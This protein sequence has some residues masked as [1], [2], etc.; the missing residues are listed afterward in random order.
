MFI[1]SSVEEGDTEKRLLGLQAIDSVAGVCVEKVANR[2]F[3]AHIS[4]R[5]QQ[6]NSTLSD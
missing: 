1:S 6:T 2:K 5:Q 3:T 4:K